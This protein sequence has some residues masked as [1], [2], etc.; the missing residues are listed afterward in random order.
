MNIG[1]NNIQEK[2]DQNL[3]KY[4]TETYNPG[5]HWDISKPITIVPWTWQ[6]WASWLGGNEVERIIT[7]ITRKSIDISG[8]GGYCGC[9][10]IDLPVGEYIMSLNVTINSVCRKTRYFRQS[11]GKYIYCDSSNVHLLAGFNEFEFQI[12]NNF[13]MRL[14]FGDTNY[15]LCTFSDFYIREK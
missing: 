3:W 6:R 11:V 10:F 1:A 13:F 14:D 7:N 4:P 15:K 9:V 8:G 5:W 12:E 2:K